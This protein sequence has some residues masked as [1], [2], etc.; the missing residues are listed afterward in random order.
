ML[1]NYF[2]QGIGDDAGGAGALEAGDELAFLF[3]FENDLHSDPGLI[4][5]AADDR[6]A[7]LDLLCSGFREIGAS[8]DDDAYCSADR[9][10]HADGEIWSA[11]LW[12]IAASLGR[13]KA[14]KLVIQHHFLL[15]ASATFN[16]AAD[17]LV[18]TARNLGYTQQ[19]VQVVR[20]TLQSRGFTVSV[21]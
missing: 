21:Q 11:A 20:T 15:S 7:T 6:L 8:H 14:D 9:V 4:G 13:I 10:G 19:E 18:T 17:A 3:F 1:R 12:Q 16:Q 2:V 5:K